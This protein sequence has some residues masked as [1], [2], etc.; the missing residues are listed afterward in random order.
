LR[1]FAISIFQKLTQQNIYTFYLDLV[2][3]R[4]RE[5]EREREGEEEEEK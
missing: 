3:P 2:T 4:E 1:K 5:R